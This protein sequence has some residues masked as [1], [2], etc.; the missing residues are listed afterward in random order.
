MIQYS[1]DWIVICFNCYNVFEAIKVVGLEYFE[2]VTQ[3]REGVKSLCR[4]S[5]VMKMEG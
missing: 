5:K 1:I 2:K 4:Y 3:I